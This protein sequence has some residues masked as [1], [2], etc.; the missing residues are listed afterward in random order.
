MK[1]KTNQQIDTVV[2]EPRKSKSSA[3]ERSMV[4]TTNVTRY[5]FSAPLPFKT[6]IYITIF[7]LFAGFIINFD[8]FQPIENLEPRSLYNNAL[9]FGLLLIGFPTLLSSLISTPIANLLDGTFYY[10]RS[11]LLAFVSC[12]ILLP[13]LVLGKILNF[14]YNFD[15]IIVFIFAYAL[16]FS[17]R[18]SVILATSNSK[19]SK[20]IL[21]SITQPVFGFLFLWFIPNTGFNVMGDELLLMII[22][23][24]IFFC[25]TVLWVRIITTPFKRN[26]GADGLILMR[27]SLSQFTED[28]NAGRVLEREFF[29]KI[30]SNSDLR[31]GVVCIKEKS[32]P[33]KEQTNKPEKTLIVIPSIHPGPFG[34]LGGSNLPAKLLKYVQ[35]TIGTSGN[36]MVFHG[37]STHD[38]N[39]VAT[40][41]C[42]K[43]GKRVRELVKQ[44]KYS[45]TVSTFHRAILDY[46][47][48]EMNYKT[49]GDKSR[50]YGVSPLTICAQ[51]LG[52]GTLFVHTSSPESTDDIDNP[53]GETIVNKAEFESDKRASFIDAHNCLEPG[54]GV[55]F[56]GS[57]KANNMVKLVSKLNRNLSVSKKFKFNSG[58]ACDQKFKV[59]D[60]L[61]PMGIQ[62]LAV[63]STNDK[64]IKDGKTNA[65]ILLDGNNVIPGL[66]ELILDGISDLVDDAEVFTTDNHIVNAT[67]GGYNPVGLKLPSEMIIERIRLVVKK[68]VSK[69]R[70][71]EVGMTTGFVRNVRILGQN[72][73]MRLSTTINS[74][75]AIMKNSLVAT[76]ALALSLCWLFAIL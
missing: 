66:R 63:E 3:V 65:Y 76:Q 18:H 53:I 25:T 37:T 17:V 35:K 26:F 23:M 32:T 70:P 14:Y 39:P 29:A 52:N 34:I 20:S 72:T 62:V 8:I 11:F 28:A 30:G 54:T 43:V 74:T 46:D 1:R 49:A 22:F 27:H 42:A 40:E 4:R 68:A 9:I 61:G 24:I 21:V 59:S 69:I 55:V 36:F 71:C 64:K 73:T 75:I 16:V 44:V 10:R 7:S 50:K 19:N 45:D 6:A 51:R 57:K 38:L 47:E 48:T 33:D 13:V 56:F 58:F 67:L 2:H 41:E 60:G 15:Y 31:L 12:V 5:L